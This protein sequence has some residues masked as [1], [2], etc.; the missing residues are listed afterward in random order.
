MEGFP[1][2]VALINNGN[3][4][5][6]RQWQTLFYDGHYSH[7]KLGGE[8]VYVPDFVQLSQALGAEAIRVTKEE[9][10]VPAIQKAREIN[11]RPVVVEFIVGEDAQVWPMI[12]A[13]ASNSDMQ[14]ALGMRPFFDMEESAGE[15]PEAINEAIEAVEATEAADTTTQEAK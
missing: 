9:D 11:D 6:V 7:T 10:V 8:E 2:K 4:G 13:G 3:L 12:A 14:Y 5:M 15:T 1:F